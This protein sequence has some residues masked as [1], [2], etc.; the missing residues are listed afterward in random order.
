MK[1]ADRFKFTATPATAG[2]AAT[3]NVS[4]AITGYRTPAQVIS[5]SASDPLGIKVGDTGICFTSDDGAGNKETSLY[6]LTSTTVLTRTE[7]QSSTAGGTTPAT[8][9]GTTLTVTNSMSGKQASA[10]PSVLSDSVANLIELKSPDGLSLMVVSPYAPKNTDGR[11][12]G[13][14]WYQTTPVG[15][16]MVVFL[17]SAGAYKAMV[18]QSADTGA[19]ALTQVANGTFAFNAKSANT[20]YGNRSIHTATEALT[21]IKAVF[22]NWYTPG[23][24]AETGTTAASTIKATLEYP[25]GSGNKYQFFFGGSATGTIPD[26]AELESEFLPISI[27]AGAEFAIYAVWTNTSGVPYFSYQVADPRAQGMASPPTALKTDLTNVGHDGNWTA[28][29]AA[30]SANAYSGPIAIVGMSANKAVMVVGD[31]LAVGRGDSSYK[32]QGFVARAFGPVCAVG[33]AGSSGDL[34]SS[35][36]SSHARRVGLA[37]YFTH[38]VMSMGINDVLAGVTAAVIAANTNTIIKY[39]TDLGKKVALCTIGPV[40]ADTASTWTAAGTQ[41]TGA[42]NT[43]RAA[44]NKQRLA[45]APLA[46][47][48]YDVNPAIENSAAPEDGLWKASSTGASQTADGTHPN[49]TGYANIAANINT[50]LLLNAAPITSIGGTTA[51]LRNITDRTYINQMKRSVTAMGGAMTHTLVSATDLLEVEFWNGYINGYANTGTTTYADTG[52]GGPCTFSCQVQVGSTFYPF[53]AA[54][55]SLTATAADGQRV[56]MRAQL[57]LWLPAGQVVKI[58]SYQKPTGSGGCTTSGTA[59]GMPNNGSTTT[60]STGVLD[61][62]RQGAVTDA[63]A[64]GNWANNGTDITGEVVGP[65]A[66]RG[67]SSRPSVLVI[68][69]SIDHGEGGYQQTVYNSGLIGAQLAAAG[70]GFTNAG[71]RADAYYKL[72]DVVDT[73]PTRVAMG[74]HPGI[75]SIYLGGA[76]N[77]I[78]SPRSAATIWSIMQEIAALFPGK[79]IV[80]ATLTPLSGLNS[81][82]VTQSPSTFINNWIALNNLIRNNT[83]GWKVIDIAK[84]LCP[85]GQP[86]ACIWRDWSL[87]V[88]GTHPSNAGYDLVR[89]SGV[90][91]PAKFL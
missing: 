1:S 17:K 78:T 30:G 76:V 39:F 24:S 50:S 68:G 72:N 12:D 69:T 74:N 29:S 71:I 13:T 59:T 4:A 48:I 26:L 67:K 60:V 77:D 82:G 34:L 61:I 54:D 32:H 10:L 5:D 6:T 15:S 91:D 9:T 63:T 41:T 62:C 65:I 19:V 45:A 31:N 8:F 64:T 83:L 18:N 55:G 46:S 28:L 87:T 37:R 2:S 89:A 38:V 20:S 33:N 88:D 14:I 22:A 23:G 52:S 56:V 3:L 21:S 70:I 84:A 66:I 7:V 51:A 43:V 44:V 42:G 49:A 16:A 35:F 86:D 79:N 90:V 40:S 47:V 58:H 25:V 57:P 27:P 85:D 53:L 81:D 75:T 73:R 36:V 11:R 80:V